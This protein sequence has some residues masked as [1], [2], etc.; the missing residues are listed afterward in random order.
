ML[1]IC[2]KGKAQKLELNLRVAAAKQFVPNVSSTEGYAYKLYN[3]NS[4][5][6]A[7]YLELAKKNIFK[8]VKGHVG[9]GFIPTFGGAYFNYKNIL[10]GGGGALTQINYS[11]QLY[12]G[13]EREFIKID[14]PLNKNYN[15]VFGGIG[16]NLS[17]RN[18]LQRSGTDNLAITKDGRNLQGVDITKEQSKYF[19]PAIYAGVRHHILNRKGKEVLGL[20]LSGNYG[21]FRYYSTTAS[22]TLNG[23]PQKDYLAEKGAFIQFGIIKRIATLKK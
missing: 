7:L 3:Q 8:N 12:V 6:P 10:Q 1:I 4:P 9:V 15:S 13:L 19:A 14:K 20:E 11:Y 16:F 18:Y 5:Y 21:L 17:G 2:V 22:Y 23:L